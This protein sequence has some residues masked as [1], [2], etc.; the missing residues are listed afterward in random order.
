MFMW[1]MVSYFDLFVS[2]I[3]DSAKIQCWN[4]LA[5]RFAIQ[6]ELYVKSHP[7][8]FMLCVKTHN[9]SRS[10]CFCHFRKKETHNASAV[11][12]RG[13]REPA[14]VN[15][16]GNWKRRQLTAEEHYSLLYVCFSLLICVNNNFQQIRNLNK[17][18]ITTWDKEL[19][20]GRI[21]IENW[22]SNIQSFLITHGNEQK[23]PS[24]S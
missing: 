6:A 7:S 8:R 11:N 19:A 22:C 12:C 21:I 9:M 3:D 13:K 1:Y 10:K 4:R 14:A 20:H 23:H 18:F 17:E 5:S 24:G 2:N 16:R 15:C